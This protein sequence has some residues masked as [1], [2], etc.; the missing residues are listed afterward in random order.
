MD[1]LNNIF[2]E[3]YRSMER[4]DFK[5]AQR[6]V[7]VIRFIGE[8][9][10]HKL[11]HTDNLIDLLYRL[12]NYDTHTRQPDLYLSTLDTNPIDSFR[13]RLVC[14]L[15][16]ELGQYFWKGARRIQM[17]RFLTFFQKY[18]YSKSYVLMDLEFM[19]LD[20][21]DKMR[22]SLTFKKFENL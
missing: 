1:L 21:F 4:N 5:E 2:E 13:I 6:R 12:I 16:D 11:L 19:I 8:A 14:T 10:N 7:A 3:I 18:I 15:L 9:Y 22:P 17:D 20:T